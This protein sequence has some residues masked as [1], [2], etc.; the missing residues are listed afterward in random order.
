MAYQSLYRRYRPRRFAEVRG[1][2]HVV[3]ALRNAVREDRV[4][5]AYLFSGPAARARRRP[6]ASSPRCST[7]RPR[8]TA[9]RDLVCES[10]LVDRGRDELRRAR[11]RRRVEQ[12]GRRHPRP[13]R[14]GRARH[15]GAHEGVH[16]RRGPHAV[17]R[18]VERAAEDARGAAARCRVRAGDHR[19]RRRCSRRSAAARSTSSSTCCPR[20][21][22]RTTS[23]TSSTTPGSTSLPTRID[24][25]VRAGR[26]SARDTLSALD[27]VVAA[28]GVAEREVSVDEIVE[29][30]AERDAGRVLVAVADGVNSGRDPRLLGAAARRPPARRVPRRDEGAARPS[31]RCRPRSRRGAHRAVRASDDHP[32]DRGARRGA[33]RHGRGRRSA[34]RARGRARAAGQRR[35]RHVAGGAARAHR[36]ARSGA[37]GRRRRGSRSSGSAA[38]RRCRERRPADAARQLLRERRGDA[39]AATPDAR[40]RPNRHLRHRASV[41]PSPPAPAATATG[42]LPTARRADLAWGD[43]LLAKVPRAA[44]PRYAG[45]RF[46]AVDERG[47]VFALPERGAPVRGARSIEPGSSRCWPT[48][49]A[50]PC[51]LV[52]VVDDG[53]SGRRC[54]RRPTAAVDEPVEEIVDVHELE[55]AP[56]D[57]RSRRRSHRRRVP[58]RRA[59]GGG[60]RCLTT[61]RRFPIS[62]GCST[63]SSECKRPVKP[64]TRARPAA[65]AVVVRASGD[66]EFEAVTHLAPTSS[67]RPTSRC[68]KT[69]CSPRCTTSPR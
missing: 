17:D 7:A 43:T 15:A 32:L 5:H 68:S 64:S 65:G 58:G 27:Q 22:S 14:A 54:P 38:P 48:T 20:R 45:G 59:R 42:E 36:T 50:G 9:S 19:S 26:G 41:A 60:R 2:D 56:P 49:S 3:T 10:C 62:E 12:Q 47:A 55:D 44:K 34:H 69:W 1:Q 30:L 63:A 51:P 35:G 67:T 37:R 40:R 61:N 21:R 28:G 33:R 11:A 24:Y 57:K 25:V 6:R 31:V 53:A 46:V 66:L 4:G 13:H 52:L 29:A 8:S 16:P 23:A 39:A 18:G